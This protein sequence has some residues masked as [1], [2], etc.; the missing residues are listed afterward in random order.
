MSKIKFIILGIICYFSLMVKVLSQP[1]FNQMYDHL[2]QYDNPVD[3]TE[4]KDGNILIFGR[5]VTSDQ[6][7]DSIGI[8]KFS[9][10]GKLIWDR[11]YQFCEQCNFGSASEIS[12]QSNDSLIFIGRH[13]KNNPDSNYLFIAYLDLDGNLISTKE[14]PSTN[15]YYVILDFI[16]TSDGGFAGCGWFSDFVEQDQVSMVFKLDSLGNLEWMWKNDNPEYVSELASD[17]EQL[18]EKFYIS[19]HFNMDIEG[20]FQSKWACFIL[21]IQGNELSHLEYL[22]FGND[23]HTSS[24]LVKDSTNLVITGDYEGK[25]RIVII[26]SLGVLQTFFDYNLGFSEEK[27]SELHHIPNQGYY[28]LMRLNIGVPGNYNIKGGLIKLN[29]DFEYEWHK[30]YGLVPGNDDEYLEHMIPTSDGGFA[31]AG[32]ITGLPAD[33]LNNTWLVKVDSL[34]ND[35]LPLSNIL[36]E[37]LFLYPNKDT[38][39]TALTFGGSNCYQNY[40]WLGSGGLPFFMDPVDSMQ[41]H[42]IAP[43]EG[44]YELIYYVEDIT[45]VPLWDTCHVSIIPTSISGSV[46]SSPAS[47]ILVAPNP[48]REKFYLT[49]QDKTIRPQ[50]IKLYTTDGREVMKMDYSEEVDIRL[51]SAGLYLVE[52]MGDTGS[53]YSKLVKVE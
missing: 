49:L 46:F 50:W 33:V 20:D 53:Y 3:L 19:Y 48:A 16:P 31:M 41:C 26:D 15:G 32:Y 22:N 12:Y 28:G 21:D 18:N 43:N 51:L 45:G 2:G 4:D 13:N 9:K 35:T 23:T 6:E 11:A 44:D 24:L 27:I 34:G 37:Q 40:E 5:N 7:T 10:Y 8:Q 25:S 29:E 47:Q 42:L 52:V 39:I 30:V 38:V 17:I 1:V 14:I 36:P